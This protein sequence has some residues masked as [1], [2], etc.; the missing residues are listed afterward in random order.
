MPNRSLRRGG[1][2]GFEGGVRGA[3]PNKPL[4]TTKEHKKFQKKFGEGVYFVI[5][6]VRM[7]AQI[8]VLCRNFTETLNLPE[9]PD[10]SQSQ[11]LG[12][13]FQ[14]FPGK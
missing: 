13:P 5:I 1:R 6:S 7:V 11:T 14:G 12:F 9:F 2:G 3:V 8:R 4:T 10:P